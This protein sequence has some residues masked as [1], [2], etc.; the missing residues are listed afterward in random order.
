MV[1]VIKFTIPCLYQLY[2]LIYSRAC[3]E[4]ITTDKAKAISASSTSRCPLAWLSGKPGMESGSKTKHSL[5]PVS[6]YICPGRLTT[7]EADQ[8]YHGGYHM[9]PLCVQLEAHQSEE[10]KEDCKINPFYVCCIWVL[11]CLALPS[12]ITPDRFK[13]WRNKS[14]VKTWLN[15]LRGSINVTLAKDMVPFGRK[16][17][18]DYIL[19]SCLIHKW[20]ICWQESLSQKVHPPKSFTETVNFQVICAAKSAQ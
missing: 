9:N 20:Q 4:R 3:S 7:S 1:S 19:F 17:L 16:C 5:S 10:I 15:S 13:G 2:L 8:V 6:S 18:G 11:L 12:Y 14:V